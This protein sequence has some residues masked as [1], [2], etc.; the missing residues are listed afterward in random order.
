VLWIPAAWH[1]SGGYTA[2]EVVDAF[3][4]LLFGGITAD[5]RN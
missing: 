1:R 3:L 5:G 4:A 2:D